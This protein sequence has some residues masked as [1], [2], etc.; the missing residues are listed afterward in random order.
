MKKSLSLLCL[1]FSLALPAVASS[2]LINSGFETG[3][4]EGWE[5]F[6]DVSI[7]TAALGT[8][9]SEGVYHALL[10]TGP[11][12]ESSED[13]WAFSEILPR[14]SQTPSQFAEGSSMKLTLNL[15]TSGYLSVD[16]NALIN[17]YPDSGR[18]NTCRFRIGVVRYDDTGNVQSSTILHSGSNLFFKPDGSVPS[19]TPFDRETGYRNWGTELH[20]GLNT[21]E[22][23]I[24]DMDAPK[25]YGLLVD[26]IILIEIDLM[27]GSDKNPINPRKKGKIPVAILSNDTFDAGIVDPE[28]CYLEGQEGWDRASPV[29]SAIEDVD[30]D[31]DL[32]MILH[33]RTQEVDVSCWDE[34]VYVGGQILGGE[35]FNSEVPINTV[36]CE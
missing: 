21:L 7:Q 4:L 33:F 30:G 10:T 29:H 15:T 3:D 19:A 20:P 17:F 16:W 27:P 26:N 18:D 14:T 22:F 34:R 6:G 32:D 1:I 24:L 2:Q 11:G 5:T 35:W 31:G 23:A 25:E 28:T 8:G 12:A 13:V 36:G 9:P